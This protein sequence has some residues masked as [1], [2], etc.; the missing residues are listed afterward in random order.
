MEI[1]DIQEYF[2]FWNKLNDSQRLRLYKASDFQRTKKKTLI[3]GNGSCLGLIL[4][5]SGQIRVFSYS[6]EGREYTLYRLFERDICLFSAS[7][8]LPDLQM[9]LMIE[10]EKDS[11]YWVIC[12]DAYKSLMDE[13]AAIANYTNQ[14]MASR[15]TSVMWLF[16]E[17]MFKSMD[18]R[19][20]SFLSEEVKIEGS[21]KLK[22]T[23]E[24]IANHLGT[25]REVITRTLQYLQGEGMVALSRGT[26]EIT[27]LAR[28]EEQ[29]E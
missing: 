24:Q 8:M 7:C 11:E 16:N 23:H 2:P 1:N 22:I 5:K 14:L 17:I 3:H 21:H 25:A 19:L 27:D 28:L 20:A 18:K 15:F 6:E 12:P 4:I 29:A 10:T 9:D 26:I 13:S